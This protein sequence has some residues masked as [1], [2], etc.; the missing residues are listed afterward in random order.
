MVNRIIKRRALLAATVI[1]IF[2]AC[3][4]ID[5][6]RMGSDL[7]PAVD[8]IH[9][10]ETFFPVIANNYIPDDSTRLNAAE[11]HPAGGI[12][13]DP[14]FGTTKATLFFE[15]KPTSYKYFF[16]DSIVKF[17]SAVLILTYRGHYGDS[18]TPVNLNLY[19]VDKAMQY[20]TSVRPVYSLQPDLSATPKLWGHKTMS[21]IQFRDSIP[22]KRGDSLYETVTNQLRIPLD[23]T[24]ASQLFSQDTTGAY[25]NDSAFKKYLPGFALAPQGN[26]SALFYFNLS[27]GSKLQF[28]FQR[29]VNG[30]IDT[31][32]ASFP[33]STICGH[34]VKLEHNRAGA[35]VNSFLTPDP[36]KGN[37][38]IY[39]QTTP[40]TMATLHIPGLDTL[41]NKVIHRAEIRITQLGETRNVS[42]LTPPNA[43][44]LDLVDTAGTFMGIPYDMSPFTPYYCFPGN[45]I[46]FSY[47]G[48]FANYE[49]VNGDSLA[50]YRFNISRYIQGIISRQ[51]KVHDLRLS[52]PFQ[53]YYQSCS[54]GSA[55]YPAQ[56]FP[57]ITNGANTN[58]VGLGRIR[59]AGGG[60]AV[61]PN[62]RM[63]LRIIYSKL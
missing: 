45:G 9:T 55:N 42:Q 4:K 48:G 2:T 12:T 46:N 24:L 22:I 39:I 20:D 51:E 28:F 25:L 3:T 62:L 18:M 32:S 14:L 30:V 36:I 47:F 57:L 7:I 27:L 44:Y 38:Q 31:T 17:D 56:V 19:E 58:P 1:T 21:A 23:Q 59:I 11:D 33:F 60:P 29:Q 52:A 54:N 13:N 37:D 49:E 63:Q 8:N 16:G 5:T 26:P 53:M 40:G 43:L 10:F 34:A 15:M 41:T 6:T 50:V 35:E 61:D